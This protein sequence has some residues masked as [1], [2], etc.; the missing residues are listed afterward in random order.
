MAGPGP[1]FFTTYKALV[2]PGYRM[3]PFILGLMSI[4][5][6]LF[7]NF[8]VLIL[9]QIEIINAMAVTATLANNIVSS[10]VKNFPKGSKY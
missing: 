3:C 4:F 6:E 2:G 7:I 5:L 9:N 1:T 10:R 8:K